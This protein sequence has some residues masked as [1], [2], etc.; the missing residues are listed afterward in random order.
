M[1]FPLFVHALVLY[2]THDVIAFIV[3]SCVAISY[4][5]LLKQIRHCPASDKVL[6]LDVILFILAAWMQ[7]T[8]MPGWFSFANFSLLA[9]LLSEHHFA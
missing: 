1:V 4:C 2:A 6:A 7:R 8:F 3:D 5:W 9:G